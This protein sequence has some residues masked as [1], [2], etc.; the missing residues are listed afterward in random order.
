MNAIHAARTVAAMAFGLVASIAWSGTAWLESTPIDMKSYAKARVLVLP[1]EITPP[2]ELDEGERRAIQDQVKHNLVRVFELESVQTLT[3]VERKRLYPYDLEELTELGQLY[4][5]DAVVAISIFSSV[6]DSPDPRS[7]SKRIG[8]R[9]TFA[10]AKTA[11]RSWTM[12]REYQ[13]RSGFDADSNRFDESVREDLSRAREELNSKYA[14]GKG[15]LPARMTFGFA[16]SARE[17]PRVLV[18]VP[19]LGAQGASDDKK[20]APLQTEQSLLQFRIIAEDATGLLRTKVT[21]KQSG[22]SQMLEY[23]SPRSNVSSN[24][25]EAVLPRRIDESIS[26]PLAGGINDVEFV[27]FNRGNLKRENTI[28]IKR[29]IQELVYTLGVGIPQ[30]KYFGASPVNSGD[31]KQRFERRA[32]QSGARRENMI[33]LEGAEASYDDI[34]SGLYNI[35][36]MARRNDQGVGL[37][38]FNGKAQA[39]PQ[40]VF[41]IAYDSEPGYVEVTG[42]DSDDIQRWCQGNCYTIL[43]LCEHDIATR[44]RVSAALPDAQISFDSCTPGENKNADTLRDQMNRGASAKEAVQSVIKQGK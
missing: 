3:S 35:G 11:T 32:E 16:S 7:Q 20:R 21:N 8:M 31:L 23:G 39:L 14:D 18:T 9:I 6:R 1:V 13:A 42:I 34:R 29:E 37:F 12:T 28:S 15:L 5:V 36:A 24:A 30:Y 44:K 41:L 22:F 40:G 19:S 43:D 10:D 27:T 2:Y 25:K 38:Y 4:A 26:V 17:K 33:F